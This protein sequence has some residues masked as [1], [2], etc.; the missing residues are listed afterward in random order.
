MDVT[1]GRLAVPRAE[2]L[3]THAAAAVADRFEVVTIGSNEVGLVYREHRLEALL[4]PGE[5][6]VLW[7]DAV[8]VRVERVDLQGELALSRHL[9]DEIVQAPLSIG[10][11]RVLERYRSDRREACR[12]LA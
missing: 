5:V 1:D 7:R 2:F 6:L 3:V 10:C 11:G 8:D 12:A 9:S 4:R